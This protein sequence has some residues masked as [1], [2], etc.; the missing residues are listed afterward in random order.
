MVNVW[1]A[2]RR[3]SR[4][5]WHHLWHRLQRASG[6]HEAKR[7]MLAPSP[8]ALSVAACL[9]QACSSQGSH[10]K[11]TT[12]QRNTVMLMHHVNSSDRGLQARRGGDSR[13][14]DMMGTHVAASPQVL[15]H[16]PS[17]GQRNDGQGGGFARDLAP[18]PTLKHK[19]SCTLCCR[20]QASRVRCQHDW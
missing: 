8:N 9:C 2:T 3:R 4:R 6:R 15:G 17:H 19:R 7:C 20:H 14:R 12:T 18:R 5:E 13:A 10:G 16:T 1:R 11:A